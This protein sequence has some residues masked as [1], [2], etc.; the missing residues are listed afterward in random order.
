MRCAGELQHRLPEHDA[1][2]SRTTR[3]PWPRCCAT[4]ATRRSRVGKWHLVPDGATRRP[5][6][7]STSGRCQRGFDRFYGFLEGETDQFHPDL[8]V[9]QPPGRPA[10]RGPRTATT[11]ARTWSTRRSVDLTTARSIRPDRPFF[12]LPRVRRDARAA[13]GAGRVPRRS[14]AAGSTR[15]GTS[16]ASGGSRASSSSGS[17]PRAPSS[18][19]ATR[20]S[21]RGTTC[22]RTS[23]GSRPAAGGVR[24]VPRPHRR[25]DRSVRRRPRATSASSTTRCSFVLADNG[26]SQEGGPFGVL[27]EMKFFNG[28][29]ETPDEAIA[30]HRRH[31]R[32]AQP[33]E[34]P[35]GL[36]AGRQ[37][38]VQVVQAEHPRGRRPRA[39]DRALA[40]RHRRERGGLRRPVPPR[41]RHRADD[42]RG[43][44]ASTPP[45]GLP[46]AR[47][48]AGHRARRCATRSPTPTRRADKP[49][50]YFEMA[51]HRGIYADGWKAVTPPPAGRAA[52]TTTRGSCTTSPR[53]SRSATT[54]P[55]TMPDKLAELVDAVVGRGRGA[56]RAPARRPLIELFGARFRDRLAAPGRPPLHLPAADVADARPGG[57]R[58]RRSQLGPHGARRRGRPATRACSTRPAPRTRASRVFVQDDRLVFDYN[59]FGDHTIVESDVEVPGRRVDARRCGSGAARAVPAR[60]A[61]EVDGRRRRR[62]RPPAVHADD[63]V[64]RPER[65]LRPRLGGV[66][67]YDAP[68]PFTGTLHE[69]VI[70]LVSPPDPATTRR[71]GRAPR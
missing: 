34:L 13:P 23:S 18:R 48:D 65:R 40:E 19:R 70:Q 42:L 44:S 35:V 22:P 2:T 60:S 54:S 56:R 55:A 38:A 6:G 15:A 9:R 52:T 62:G 27:H 10:A 63:L 11:S 39:A 31:R 36:G 5:P 32:P 69:V 51:G 30:P 16:P 67:R 7:R 61:I 25:P 47:A 21:S 49:V 45:D 26:A 53:T 33:L 50:Q 58:D 1:A 46:R 57:G 43:R 14:T 37:H 12:L 41:E 17:S 28:I 66:D 68:F 4:R 71:R 59:A 20:A 8:V 64:G 24:R 29:L 3:R